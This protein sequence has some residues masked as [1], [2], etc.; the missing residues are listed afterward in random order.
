MTETTLNSCPLFGRC[1]GCR[2]GGADYSDE[3]HTKEEQLKKLFLPVLGADFFASSSYEGMLGS[4]VSAGYRNKMEFSFGN[5]EKDG[6]L[7]LGLHQKKSFFNIF[8]PPEQCAGPSPAP[9]ITR[10]VLQKATAVNLLKI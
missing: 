6:P 7:T 8:I 9:A 10:S 2:Y 3:L 4:P 1:G 5:A